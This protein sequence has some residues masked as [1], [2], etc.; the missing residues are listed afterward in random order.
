[1][2]SN[3]SDVVDLT[4]DNDPV[5]PASSVPAPSDQP[6]PAPKKRNLPASFNPTANNIAAGSVP[7]SSSRNHDP[8]SRNMDVRTSQTKV[9][10]VLHNAK[11]NSQPTAVQP[12]V[13]QPGKDIIILYRCIYACFNVVYT[14]S[15]IRRAACCLPAT[16][17]GE[18]Q[19]DQCARVHCESRERKGA[20][21]S[22]T[23]N[24]P[25]TRYCL[26]QCH[27]FL[28]LWCSNACQQLHAFK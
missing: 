10:A 4:D 6:P 15:S 16:G 26:F 21:R 18:V 7:S 28:L 12:R 17:Q 2:S 25:D 3:A 24:H 5:F 20:L 23:A 22:D 13:Q 9:P 14:C 19:A 8:Y 11:Q 1:M 27:H